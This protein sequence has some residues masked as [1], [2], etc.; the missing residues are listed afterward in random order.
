MNTL[1]AVLTTISTISGVLGALIWQHWRWFARVGLLFGLL[2][3]I[4]PPA[5]R[6]VLGPQQSVSSN[7]PMLCVHTRLIDEVFEWKI[8][9]SLQLVREMGADHIVEFFPWAYIERQPG[10][11]DWAQTDKILRHAENQGLQL[12]ARMG[13][14][15]RWAQGDDA[16]D[17]AMLNYLPEAAY[18]DFARFVATFAARYAATVD[19]LIIWNEP[20]LAFEWGFQQV[21]A[22][23][24]VDLLQVVY[25]QVKQA[26]PDMII[27]AGALA[28]TLEPASSPNGL[29]D[30]I[31]LQQ[32]LAAGAADH[33]DGLA[34]HTYGFTQPPQADPSPDVLNFRRAEL[35]HDLL[36]EY[37]LQMPVTIT[38]SGWNDHPR[39]TQAVRPAQRV[40][41]TVDALR[42]A[43]SNWPWLD[44]L[45]LW[46]F[47]YPAPT[48]SYPDYYTLVTPDFTLK[49]IYYALQAYA[50]SA[51]QTLDDSLWLPAPTEPENQTTQPAD[52]TDNVP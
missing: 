29:N 40:Q 22:N 8:Q 5:P 25:E 49:P 3:F 14:V 19:H 27:L 6:A 20:N 31:Y 35:L 2:S 32:M 34:V 13:F 9:R 26:N 23:S 17:F 1:R 41:Y 18:D 24:Y 12:I 43:E 42:Y 46:A 47:R 11:Y 28:P 4:A 51:E 15:P 33:M 52:Q 48:Y 39:W 45:C 10:R 44:Q 21:D 38:E 16:G 36:N 50:T 30:L 37:A 7:S